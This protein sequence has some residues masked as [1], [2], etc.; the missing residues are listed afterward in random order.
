M[1]IQNRAIAVLTLVTTIAGCSES[2]G[3]QPALPPPPSNPGM[4]SVSGTI[5][6]LLG[7]GLVLRSDSNGRTIVVQQ[8]ATAF[9]FDPVPNGTAYSV[10]VATSP[11]N[12]A[13]LCEVFQGD[14]VAGDTNSTFVRI[15]CTS[16][17][18]SVGGTITGL[19]GSGLE[20]IR[21]SSGYRYV[22]SA[23]PLPGVTEFTFPTN[24]I[25][26]TRFT[27]GVRSQPVAPRQTCTLQGGKGLMA[28][29]IGIS[30]VDI[31]CID[32]ETTPLSGTYRLEVS[33]GKAGYMT[34]F[35][36]GTYS[37]ALR[38]DDPGCGSSN[39]NGVEYGVYNW[40]G[41]TTAFA[42]RTAV[43][44]TNGSCGVADF[45]SEVPVLLSGVLD[46]S[47]GTL[48]IASGNQTLTLHAVESRPGTV[49]GSWLPEAGIDLSGAFTVFAANDTYVAVE[50]QNATHDTVYAGAEWGCAYWS[51]N[52]LESVTCGPD[53]PR[54]LDMNGTGGLSE[55]FYNGHGAINMAP[56][57][58][59]DG[60]YLSLDAADNPA[61]SGIVDAWHEILP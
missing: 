8:G 45:S 49:I 59:Y 9:A 13:Q 37:L 7:T 47:D 55:R 27:I 14:G 36:D 50:T 32:N 5:T 54:F 2:T 40:N 24:L 43:V 4:T 26:G 46:R 17:I 10:S 35:L 56:W 25:V 52:E 3:L 15:E 34:F 53:Q 21:S 39:G 51:P 57:N 28:D 1:N 33:P 6:G 41:A 12:P 61:G 20:L 23:M 42:I 38:M 16:N 31:T 48:L 29:T 30:N 44:D 11:Q 18:G 60:E 22:D 58:D 19:K